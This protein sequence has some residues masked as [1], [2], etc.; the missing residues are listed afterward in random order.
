MRTKKFKP[1]K[2]KGSALKASK[3]CLVLD[4]YDLYSLDL[5]E[6]PVMELLK[7]LRLLFVEDLVF[8]TEVVCAR[9]WSTALPF[10]TKA[11]T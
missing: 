3:F 2:T 1:N 7:E 8:S 4:N 11:F 5:K 6:I 10:A 9:S